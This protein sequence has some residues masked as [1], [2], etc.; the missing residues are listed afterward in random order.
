MKEGSVS[1]NT[2]VD[3]TATERWDY[4]R[5]KHLEA[6]GIERLHQFRKAKPLTVERTAEYVNGLSPWNIERAVWAIG[7]LLK[8]ERAKQGGSMLEVAGEPAAVR[9]MRQVNYGQRRHDEPV[10]S[11][12]QV[13]MVL[14]ALADHTAIMSALQH[15][16]D[17]NSPWPEATSIG[18]WLHDVGDYLDWHGDD[19]PLAGLDLVE[20]ARTTS[21]IVSQTE[22]GDAA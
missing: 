8:Q 6:E 1:D 5:L 15:R 21:A 22:I 3:L 16:R 10:P 9:L 11:P 7:L 17:E 19:Q 2:A 18:R 4:D 13:A 12:R 14:H 20:H